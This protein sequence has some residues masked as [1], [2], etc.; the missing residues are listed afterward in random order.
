M[1]IRWSGGLLTETRM[2]VGV[3]SAFA[4]RRILGTWLPGRV[5]LMRHDLSGSRMRWLGAGHA[6][7]VT[8]WILHDVADTCLPVLFLAGGKVP[9]REARNGGCR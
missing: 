6:C 2:T 9:Y 3:I 8:I 5:P 4:I 1:G 7:S